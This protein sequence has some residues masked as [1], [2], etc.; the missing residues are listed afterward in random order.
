MEKLGI[1]WSGQM[2]EN[3]GMLYLDDAAVTN[4][5]LARNGLWQVVKPVLVEG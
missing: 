2:G 4:E 1:Y 3:Q 5:L